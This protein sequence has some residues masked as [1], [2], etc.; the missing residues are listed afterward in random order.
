MTF[1]NSSDTL[2]SPCSQPNDLVNPNKDHIFFINNAV[3]IMFFSI[4]DK[5]THLNRVYVSE[6][7]IYNQINVKR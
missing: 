7:I 4:E 1:R 3:L 2:Y 6:L 5:L